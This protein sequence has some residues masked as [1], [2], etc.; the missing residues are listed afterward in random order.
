MSKIRSHVF[1]Y[2][3]NSITFWLNKRTH[4]GTLRFRLTRLIYSL[5]PYFPD[6]RNK[7]WDFVLKYFPPLK[8]VCY[9]GIQVLDIGCVDSLLI[10]ELSKRGYD[11]TGFDMRDFPVRLPKEIQFIKGD[12]V[13][14]KPEDIFQHRYHYIIATSV[15]ELLGTKQYGNETR[16]IDADRKALENI[17]ALL[18]N[19]GY[20]IMSLPIF[21]WRS[22]ANKAYTLGNIYNLINGLFHIFE[23]T[24][25]GGHIC[26]VLVK[27]I[28]NKDNTKGLCQYVYKTNKE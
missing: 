20:L 24:Q 13:K 21:Y 3:Q 9:S 4:F 7:R 6:S 17:H 27:L 15:I 19:D 2:I 23:I 16:D 28:N 5:N 25:C 22:T 8:M 11:V 18:E 26:M 14:D 1:M 10:Y 12:I